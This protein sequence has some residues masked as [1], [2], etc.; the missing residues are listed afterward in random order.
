L[1]IS[2]TEGLLALQLALGTSAVCRLEALL[3]AVQF[4]AHRRALRLGSHASGVA[5]SRLAHCLALVAGQLLAGVFR[6][7]DGANWS[8]AVNG[9]F[10]A[11]Y[12]FAFHFAL[13]TSAHRVANSRALRVVAHP[14]ADGVAWASARENHRIGVLLGTNS[15]YSQQQKGEEN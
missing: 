3:A 10:S 12:L 13:R 7:A 9:A 2:I 8:L 11:R 5:T 6:A 1:I 15:H 4:L 14:L